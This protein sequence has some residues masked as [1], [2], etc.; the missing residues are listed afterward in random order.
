MWREHNS[1]YRPKTRIHIYSKIA[2]LTFFFI[3]IRVEEDLDKLLV[4]RKQVQP[5]PAVAQKPAVK[6]KPVI[7][8]KPSSVSQS[9]QAPPQPAVAQAMDQHDILKYIQQNEAAPSEDL[10]LF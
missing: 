9:G 1:F 6:A 7:P 8:P 5:K 10:D 2:V 3:F 4:I